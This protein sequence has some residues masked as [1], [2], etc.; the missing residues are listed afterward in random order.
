MFSSFLVHGRFP[1]YR[2]QSVHER[3]QGKEKRVDVIIID[4]LDRIS[5]LHS[6]GYFVVLFDYF[7]A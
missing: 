5:T 4:K 2:G 6:L 7:G 3:V 1:R